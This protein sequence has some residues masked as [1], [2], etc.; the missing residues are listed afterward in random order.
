MQLETRSLRSS[1]L[2]VLVE[3][4]PEKECERARVEQRV[5]VG[6]AG[7]GEISLHGGV[8][9]RFGRLAKPC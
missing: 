7:D 8:I 4:H 1:F 9:L 6:V 3:Q 2:H 5:G